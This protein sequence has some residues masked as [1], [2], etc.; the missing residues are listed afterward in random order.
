MRSFIFVVTRPYRR[1][2]QSKTTTDM[3]KSILFAIA[4]GAIIYAC[5]RTQPDNTT[6][7]VQLGAPQFGGAYNP[8]PVR[9]FPTSK[10][11]VDKWISTLDNRA[12]RAHGWDIWESINTP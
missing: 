5:T 11:T 8:P 9:S 10:A 2:V 4:I 6:A 1:F 3:K 12:I 7:T